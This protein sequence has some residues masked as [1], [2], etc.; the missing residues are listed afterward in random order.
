[1]RPGISSLALERWPCTTSRECRVPSEWE[2][3]SKTRW[4]ETFSW[5]YGSTPVP[6]T[7]HMRTYISL[8]RESLV[9][10]IIY[11][12]IYFLYTTLEGSTQKWLPGKVFT[13]LSL[14]SGGGATPG[15]SRKRGETWLGSNITLSEK[16]CGR[17]GWIQVVLSFRFCVVRINSSRTQ[18]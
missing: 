3:A 10:H 4:I 12:Y 14:G 15:Y 16:K 1:M 2:T 17:H 9:K 18:V 5:N 7:H 6:V 11:I 8:Y 13:L